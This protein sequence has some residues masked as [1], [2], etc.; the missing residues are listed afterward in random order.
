MGPTDSPN[1][2][3]S[4][5]ASEADPAAPLPSIEEALKQGRLIFV[6]EDNATNRMQVGRQLT[7]LGYQAEYAEDGEAA[8]ALWRE[9]PYGLVLTDCHIP[10]LDG[11]DLARKIRDAETGAGTRVPIIALTANTLVAEAERC[12]GA[13][14]DDYLVKPATLRDLALVLGRW[15]PRVDGNS[16]AVDPVSRPPDGPKHPIDVDMLADLLGGTG[17]DVVAPVFA[18]FEDS[19]G[20]ALRDLS[21]ALAAADRVA[22]KRAAHLA[23]GS[24]SSVGAED[25]TEALRKIEAGALSLDWKRLE[26]LRGDVT[27]KAASALAYLEAMAGR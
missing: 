24:S 11:F 26:D 23:S 4:P 9:K 16:P 20:S 8:F 14:M 25:L 13:G 17:P 10:S 2:T 15:L 22:L 6:A 19:L 18:S 3:A 12:L 1:E 5:E 21:Q 7:A 27:R